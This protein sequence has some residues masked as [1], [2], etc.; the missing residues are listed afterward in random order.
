MKRN[1]RTFILLAFALTSVLATAAS[2]KKAGKK[3]ANKQVAISVQEQR[4][5]DYFFY[6]AVRQ[7]QLHNLDGTVDLLTKCFYINPNSAAVAYEFGMAFTAVQDVPHAIQ[8]MSMAARLDPSNSWYKMAFAEL[9]IKSNDF[10]RAILVYED[11]SLNHPEKEDIDYMLASLYKQVGDIKKSVE[12]LNKV[13]KRIGVNEAITTEKYRMLASLGKQKEANAEFDKLIAKFP[14]NIEY[15]IQRSDMYLQEKNSKKAL[16]CIDDAK[17]V[18]PENPLLVIAYYNYYLQLG[19]TA[20]ADKQYAAAFDNKAISIE[21]KIGLLAQLLSTDN[22]SVTK[23]ET[24]F[25]QLITNNPDNETLRSYYASF[26]MMQRRN[27]EAMPQ[28][29]A[30]LAQN[31]KNKESWLELTKLYAEQNNFEKVLAITDSAII[32]L[33]NEESF[34][35]YKGIALAQ[36]KR[37]EEAIETY[38]TGASKIGEE[39]PDKLAEFYMQIADV[40]A[41]QK[42]YDAAFEFYEK[43]YKLDANS[44]TLLNNYAYY[45][46]LVNKD[47]AK[48]ETMSAK[49]VESFPENVSFLDTYAWIFFKQ[50]NYTLAR[51]YIQQAIDKGGNTS[52]VVLEHMGDIL[53]KNG[54]TEDAIIWWQKAIDAGGNSPLLKE[55]IEKKTYIAE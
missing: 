18:E 34:Y 45:L 24:Y 14:L 1:I 10:P 6:E 26:L 13:E 52:V 39:K 40:L 27:K 42:K 22:Q 28:L 36:L 55:K 12:S 15:K 4:K 48:A 17:K 47:L 29:R 49:T 46:S 53:S 21:N 25:K 2:T 51:M 11:I 31:N 3:S 19:D 5:F 8:F 16:K 38:K 9:C 41:E 35:L 33:P 30:V 50:G 7:R 23:V 37:S 44:A 54:A 20:M 43:A 32:N